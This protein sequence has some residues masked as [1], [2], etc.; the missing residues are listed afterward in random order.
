MDPEEAEAVT[1]QILSQVF[2]VEDGWAHYSANFANE[3]GEC[4][5]AQFQAMVSD[6]IFYSG[7]EMVSFKMSSNLYSI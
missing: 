2:E 7:C 4:S 1:G 5:N 3:E 6:V